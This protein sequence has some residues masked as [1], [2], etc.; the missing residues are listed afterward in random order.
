M[1]I[2]MNELLTS[3]MEQKQ[4][5]TVTSLF[6]RNGFKIAATDFDDVTFERESVL[7]NVRF[8]ASSNVESISVL[9]D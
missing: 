3:A 9:N 6:A 1:E 7:V 2:T 4:R 5:T 8:D